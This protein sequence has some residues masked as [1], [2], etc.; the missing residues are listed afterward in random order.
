MAS[1]SPE[2]P[3]NA[4]S[5]SELDPNSEDT[6]PGSA[7]SST[8][9]AAGGVSAAGASGGGATPSWSAEFK[10]RRGAFETVSEGEDGGGVFEYPAELTA[11]ERR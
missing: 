9:G 11:R 1:T 6:G 10:K 3:V 2:K 7:S 8:S 5:G 4:A